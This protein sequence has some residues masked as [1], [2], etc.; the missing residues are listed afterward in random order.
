MQVE[1][2]DLGG[3]QLRGALFENG[4]LMGKVHALPSCH[5]SV[6]E[7]A[8]QIAEIS[9][10]IRQEHA[11]NAQDSRRT[12]SIGV[13]GP[14][15]NGEMLC[16]PPLRI[17]HS[18]QWGEELG[19]L[20]HVCVA[21]DLFIAGHGLRRRLQLAGKAPRV[22]CLLALSTGIGASILLDGVPLE[23]GCEIGHCCIE[24]RSDH[25]KQCLDHRGCWASEASGAA[26]DYKIKTSSRVRSVEEFFADAEMVQGVREANAKGLSLL[27]NAY[28]PN[29]IVVMGSLGVGQFEKI[30]PTEAE[31]RHYPLVH[32]MP[33]IRPLENSQWIGLEGAYA[34]AEWQL[35]K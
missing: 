9:H 6:Q 33:D 1:C 26:V 27:I 7:S 34:Y 28:G 2:F 12:L 3:T 15:V 19:T 16:S 23:I 20:G 25:Q 4:K 21:N 5:G 31:V 8:R 17:T 35:G 24:T 18:V 13:P 30:M 14:V 11:V 29:L 10:R 22:T 32:L